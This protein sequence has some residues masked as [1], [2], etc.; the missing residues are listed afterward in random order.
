MK[1]WITTFQATGVAMFA[2]SIIATPPNAFLAFWGAW[3]VLLGF[4]F[5]IIK[6]LFP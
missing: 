4:F 5:Y 6:E 1:Y 2:G 3:L